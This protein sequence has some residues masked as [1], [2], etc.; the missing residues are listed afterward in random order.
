MGNFDKKYII[1]EAEYILSECNKKLKNNNNNDNS[2]NKLENLKIKYKKLQRR[3]KIWKGC[4]IIM[5]LIIL[6]CNWGRR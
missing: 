6:L 5:S 4:T 3:N 1:R 2:K